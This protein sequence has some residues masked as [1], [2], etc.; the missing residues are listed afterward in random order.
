MRSASL[1]ALVLL[2]SSVRADLPS[3]RLD[4]VTPLGATAGSSVEVEVLGGDIEDANTLLFD[5]KG[6]TAKHVKDRKFAVTVAAD[7]PAGT[8]D[9]R[10]VGKY[11]VTNPRLFA[12]SRGLTEVAEKGANDERAT[13]QLVP[14]NC[15]INGN[16]K[17]GKEAVFRFTREE[18]AARRR[19][20]LRAAARFTTRRQPSVNRFRRQAARFEWR[21]RRQRPARGVHRAQRR[22]LLRAAQRPLLPRRLPVPARHIGHSAHRERVPAC[23]TGRQEDRTHHLR[24]QPRRREAVAVECQRP[25]TRRTHRERHAARR[26]LE[27]RT[28]P[29][30]RSPDR[31]Q[32]PA[33]RGHLH[34]ERLP[35]PR[36]AAAGHRSADHT[37][38]RTER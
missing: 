36:R 11:G 25:V 4:R 13:A 5:H 10:L 18:G 14:V 12:V 23:G 37:G 33:H 15:V 31:A 28:V 22:R 1:L 7:V 30:H 26:H 34:P 16:S 27:A 3:P 17:G 19:G 24:A 2:V 29:L 6:I 8:Y 21:L 35:A 32:R 20:V 38:T 9:A